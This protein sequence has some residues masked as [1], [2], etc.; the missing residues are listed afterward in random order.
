MGGMSAEAVPGEP[1][2]MATVRSRP[3]DF[4][5]LTKPRLNLLVVATTA[6]GYYLGAAPC[7]ARCRR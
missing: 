3:S 7:R 2:A 4:V 1:R 5:A 6:G